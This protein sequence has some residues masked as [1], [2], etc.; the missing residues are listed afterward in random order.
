[1]L[2][3]M[4][5]KDLPRIEACDAIDAGVAVEAPLESDPMKLIADALRASQIPAGN[6][7]AP[8]TAA[9]DRGT[10]TMTKPRPQPRATPPR[11]KRRKKRS[12]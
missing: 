11:E 12:N 3:T 2:D 1:M 9:L 8:E 6:T 10:N 5:E 4:Q 7:P